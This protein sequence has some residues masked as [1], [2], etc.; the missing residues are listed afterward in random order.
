MKKIIALTLIV[1]T[2]CTIFATTYAA[3]TS[4][5]DIVQMMKSLNIMSGYSDGNMHLEDKLTRAQ[6]AKIIVNASPYKNSVSSKSTT[7]PFKDVPYSSWSAPY[8]SVAVAS[9]LITGYPDSSFKPDKN[10]TLEE[11]VTVVLN[12]MGYTSEDF[13]SSWP[14]GQLSLATNIGLLKNSSVQAGTE[15]TRNDA[16]QIIYNMLNSNTKSGSAYVDSLGYEILE[17]V[18]LIATSDEDSSISVGKISTSAG[19]Y[20]ITSM[21]NVENIGRKGNAILNN[22]DEIICFIPSDD[23]IT[24]YIAYAAI[25]GDII[26]SMSGG[27]TESLGL[28]K[29]TTVYYKGTKT[30]VDNIVSSISVGDIIKV[31]YSRGNIDFVVVSGNKMQGPVIAND[32]NWSNLFNT[33]N[34]NVIVMRNGNKVSVNDISTY[35]VLYYSQSLNILWAYNKKITGIYESASPNKDQPSSVAI[36][37]TEYSLETADAF[38]K[39]S[40]KGVFSIGDSVTL[41]IGK[42]GKIADVI[43]P[44]ETKI[45]I[46]GYLIGSGT[47]NITNDSGYTYNVNYVEI[48]T[49]DGDILEYEANKNYSSMVNSVVT[50]KFLNG[51]AVLSKTNGGSLSGIFD[52][53]NK[54]LGLTPIATGINIIDIGTVDSSMNSKYVITYP[55]RINNVKINS[56]NI[57]YYNKNKNG[58]IDNLILKNVTGDSLKYGIVLDAEVTTVDMSI[59]S[60][61]ECDVNGTTMTL[62][63]S[64]SAYTNVNLG[65]P[66]AFYIDGTSIVSIKPLSVVSTAITDV[67]GVQL[68]TSKGEIYLLS[69]DV[70]VYD[71]TKFTGY[72]IIPLSD[73]IGNGGYNIKAY[74]DKSES[75]GGRIRVIIV[76]EK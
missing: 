22:N 48:V 58:E 73:I 27:Y 64:N 55:Q 32:S 36:S 30:T 37:G 41:L 62:S 31:S 42:D 44:T 38:N 68:E 17:D 10:V 20:K 25:D 76:T 47:K 67:N 16:M 19:T 13:G 56:S 6:F 12:L 60:K 34:S 14:Y 21:F 72:D 51:L 57:L 33:N 50:I 49:T 40:S 3:E 61:Y 29:S 26:V 74:Y 63:S 24:T 4:S 65:Q 70:V 11:A 2:F 53:E 1:L 43:S 5:D 35:D 54:K 15:I 8:I 18:I 23:Q 45:N 69:S 52:W 59:S 7:S 71:N 28:N 39:L 46:I 66:A 75:S 9:K